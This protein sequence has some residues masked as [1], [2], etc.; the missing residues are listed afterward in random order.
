MK[1]L[2]VLLLFLAFSARAGL[3][4][5][6]IPA[7]TAVNATQ[8][9][10]AQKTQVVDPSGNAVT[11][12]TI[13]GGHQALDVNAVGIATA[14]V[15]DLSASGTLTTTCSGGPA[16]GSCPTGSTVLLPINGVASAQASFSGTFSGATVSI[17][18]TVDGTNWVELLTATGVS[19]VYSQTP[20]D[21]SSG[22]SGKWRVFR[23]AG[24]TQLRARLQTLSSGSVSV[25]MNASIGS[26]LAEAVQLNAANFL[27][28]AY[29]NDGSGNP[30][31]S[32]SGSLDTNVT[33]TV[34]VSQ[35]GTWTTGRTWDLSNSTDSA[36]CYQGG[37]WTAGRTWTLSSGSDSVA[38]TQ[39][40]TWT[41]ARSWNLSSGSDSVA[42]TQSG[43]WTQRLQDGSGNAIT[44]QANGAQRALDVGV[45]VAG[46]QVDP[47]ARTWNL[48][49]SSD[50]VAAF[51]G[52]GAW[53]VQGDTA[54]G[55]T[56]SGNPVKV[57]GIY[58]STLSAVSTGQR[59]NLQVNQ[60]GELDVRP[61]NRYA[62]YAGA[63]TN[64]V[65][66]GPG[67]FSALCVNAGTG[68]TTATIYDNTSGTGT[69]IAAIAFNAGSTIPTCIRYDV[70]FSTGLTITTTVGGT[71]ITV[72]YQ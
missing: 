24:L 36:A 66:T 64:T 6:P 67:I 69:V 20:F 21:P 42:A 4:V 44:S 60:Y 13:A 37:S 52:D 55:S 57:G 53:T 26:N 22:V 33:N 45:D 46:V 71:D 56:D 65:K 49:N 50:S 1:K 11:S 62:H 51:Q 12:S 28:T 30:I 32:S 16:S 63:A 70:P 25:E 43:T 31:S 34:P 48:S 15:G 8:T 68:S 54:S 58:N 3:T 39:S 47:R 18:G 59:K 19:N 41:T 72:L 23:I 61:Q 10:G 17:D 5:D 7:I 9:S 29:L 40:G 2:P 27:D 14:T 35:S 38:A